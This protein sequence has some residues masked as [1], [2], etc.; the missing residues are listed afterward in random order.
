M[1]PQ[2][3][4]SY[5]EEFYDKEKEITESVITVINVAK[6][7]NENIDDP[8][9]KDNIVNACKEAILRTKHFQELVKSM[10]LFEI[11]NFILTQNC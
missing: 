10:N 9:L 11:L 6:S 8:S 7:E 4:R 2:L 3:N 1:N 5:E